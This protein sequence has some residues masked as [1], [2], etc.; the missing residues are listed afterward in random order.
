M[1]VRHFL[2]LTDLSPAEIRQVIR[3]GMEM[4]AELREGDTEVVSMDVLRHR[5]AVL[6]FEKSSTR[7]RMS[8]ETGITHLGGNAIF[9]SP[10]DSHLARGEPVADTARV[11]SRM[12]SLVIMRTGEHQRLVDMARHSRVPVINGLSDYNHPCQL[13][14]DMQTWME[15]RGE[16][17]GRR[18]AWIGDGNN[19]C[20]SWMN[21][22]RLLDFTLTV[23]TPLAMSRT[24]SCPF[25]ALMRFPSSGRPGRR[26]KTPTS[27]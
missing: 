16:I 15:H 8:F 20:H 21:A 26:W 12:A 14:A 22:A 27:W 17:A 1:S 24:A 13:L 5:T 2:S 19:V 23:A 18:V 10:S 7:T 11:L 9:L 3:R 6:V 25:V 4:K